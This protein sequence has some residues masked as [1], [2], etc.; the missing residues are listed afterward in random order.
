MDKFLIIIEK[1]DDNYSAY[2]PDL[3]GCVATGKTPQEARENMVEAI[4]MH[5][6]GLKEDGLPIPVPTARADY[7]GVNLQAL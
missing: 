6:Q 7:I 3:P 5:L 1:A 2:S 4:K